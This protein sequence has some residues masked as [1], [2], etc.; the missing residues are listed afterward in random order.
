MKHKINFN[1]DLKYPGTNISRGLSIFQKLLFWFVGL[2][3]FITF[4]SGFIH[5]FYAKKII[6]VS[7]RKELESSLNGAIS[8]FD[9]CSSTWAL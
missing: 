3:I 5:Y 8:Y 2:S 7:V 1:P 9:N 6:E 4:T